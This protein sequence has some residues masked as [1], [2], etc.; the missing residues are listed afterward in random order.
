MTTLEYRLH[1]VGPE[2]MAAAVMYP[3]EQATELL[4]AWRDYTKQASG[5]VTS[6][7]LLWSIPD[8]PDFPKELRGEPTV[9]V[10]GMY[11]GPADIGERELHRCASS[12]PH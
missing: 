12:E 3:F 1:P 10:A 6:E 11:T 2:V 4:H 7:V 8:I 5:E 9:V